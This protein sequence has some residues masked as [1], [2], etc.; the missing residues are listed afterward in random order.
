[1]WHSLDESD[2]LLAV[3]PRGK[4]HHQILKHVEEKIL[5]LLDI[6]LDQY[7]FLDVQ[8]LIYEKTKLADRRLV[9]VR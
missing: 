4:H 6:Q 7:N 1:M 3:I 5:D 2:K 9:H 8:K